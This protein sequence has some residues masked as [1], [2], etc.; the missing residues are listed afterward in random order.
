MSELPGLPAKDQLNVP[1][2]LLFGWGA[3]RLKW[4]RQKVVLNVMGHMWEK[5]LNGGLKESGRQDSETYQGWK[6]HPFG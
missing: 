6:H 2:S 5:T 1:G 4:R 3:G